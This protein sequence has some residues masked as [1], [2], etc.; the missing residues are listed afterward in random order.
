[1]RAVCVATLHRMGAAEDLTANQ[2]RLE[3]HETPPA[4]AQCC[5]AQG[6]A[7]GPACCIK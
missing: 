3:T 1:M 7:D 5:F 2:H 6:H 4:E